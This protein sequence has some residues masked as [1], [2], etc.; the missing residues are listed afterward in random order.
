M[1]EQEC[2]WLKSQFAEDG[3][4]TGKPCRDR[5]CCVWKDL[6][7][8]F[9]YKAPFLSRNAFEQTFRDVAHGGTGIY[10]KLSIEGGALLRKAAVENG[11]N[12]VDHTLFISGI[13]RLIFTHAQRERGVHLL[14]NLYRN[15]EAGMINDH[16][17]LYRF[18]RLYLSAAQTM[19]SPR[20]VANYVRVCTAFGLNALTG[21][22]QH[23]QPTEWL[24]TLIL[25]LG[26]F[27]ENSDDSHRRLVWDLQVYMGY[28]HQTLLPRI[29][30]CFQ[31]PSTTPAAT[32]T[33]GDTLLTTFSQEYF[34]KLY[35]TNHGHAGELA[36]EFARIETEKFTSS[37]ALQV[38]ACL[39]LRLHLIFINQ[40][41]DLCTW[42]SPEE[43]KAIFI[44][45]L[46]AC[47]SIS[48]KN[49]RCIWMANIFETLRQIQLSLALFKISQIQTQGSNRFALWEPNVPHKQMQQQQPAKSDTDGCSLSWLANAVKYV[50]NQC[51]GALD[52]NAQE[53][54]A[55]PEI[56]SSRGGRPEPIT[57]CMMQQ[58]RTNLQQPT[59]SL[60][61]QVCVSRDK[62]AQTHAN[63]KFPLDPLDHNRPLPHHAHVN[64]RKTRLRINIE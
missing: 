35:E 38:F 12:D 25:H 10:E 32:E 36:C 56:E 46:G 41:I 28:A 40:P 48:P 19:T 43:A 51:M 18:G 47:W 59:G 23:A 11:P 9:G 2:P 49:K 33:P 50:G 37:L 45:L 52:S 5:K 62:M 14:G 20:A 15:K 17:N 42:R 39:Y 3:T 64:T 13:A 53:E 8:W 6:K 7:Q 24:P 1:H 26:K 22:H 30:E 4:V 63:I 58:Q 57:G 60:P 29:R 27:F 55:P 31:D 16:G 34:Y 54:H 61:V 44:N 21:P